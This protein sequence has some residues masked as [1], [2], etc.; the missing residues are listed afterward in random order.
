MIGIK[1]DIFL[2]DS[3]TG[4]YLQLPIVPEKIPW[5]DGDALPDTVRIL[6]LGN[7]DF[8]NGV[9]LDSLTLE[10]F[11]P[12]NYDPFLCATS[13]ILKPLEYRNKISGWKDSGRPVQVVIPAAGINHTM[14]VS[15]FTWEL[16][17]FEGDLY[18]SL[19]FRQ[20]KTIKPKQ[21]TPGGTA[22][23]PNKKTAADRTAAPKSNLP[24]TYTVKSGDTLIRIAKSLGIADWRTGLYNKN[25]DV[26]GPDPGKIYPGQVLKL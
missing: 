20:Y 2:Q 17:G 5:T 3:L 8:P 21:L 23:D 26:I 1:V 19:M 11:F 16:A 15:N 13:N 7:I 22:P 10:A 6:N 24:K 9:D 12:A 18:Y 4:E 14:Y 25:K